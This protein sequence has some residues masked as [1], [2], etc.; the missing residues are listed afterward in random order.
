MV[1]K[2]LLVRCLYNHS[3][4]DSLYVRLCKGILGLSREVI[5]FR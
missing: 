2:T 1:P 4:K 3:F 5:S